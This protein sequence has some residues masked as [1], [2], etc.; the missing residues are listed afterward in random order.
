M[1]LLVTLTTG[2]SIVSVVVCDGDDGGVA[3][4]VGDGG[5]RSSKF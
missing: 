2:V 5:G 3:V 4:A 1:G